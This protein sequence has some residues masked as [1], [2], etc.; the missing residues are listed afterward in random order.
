MSLTLTESRSATSS[1]H[2]PIIFA[3]RAVNVLSGMIAV[4][5]AS[6]VR[7]EQGVQDLCQYLLAEQSH[8]RRAAREIT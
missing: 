5:S 1:M 3:L 6:S 2:I 7:N 4:Q 8:C